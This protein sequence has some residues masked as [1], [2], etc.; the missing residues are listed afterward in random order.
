MT[1]LNQLADLYWFL[2]KNGPSILKNA[3]FVPFQGQ[4]KPINILE[5]EELEMSDCHASCSR[6]ENDKID[7]FLR[8][9][10]HLGQNPRKIL[11]P[12]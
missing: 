9:F 7:E 1:F 2:A 6:Y 10:S 12:E 3:Y 11:I 4:N 8:I 5:G